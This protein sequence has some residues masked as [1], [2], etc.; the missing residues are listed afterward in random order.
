MW[1]YEKRLQFPVRIKNPDARA[2]KIIISQFGGPDGELAA[3]MRYLSQRYATPYRNVAGILTDIGTE[4][5]AHMEMVCAIVHQLTRD[6]TIEQI[7]A[8]G[9]ADYFVDHTL[10][11]YPVA[12]SGAPFTATYFQSKGDIIT[13]L[14]EDMAA[15]QKARTTY[16]NILRLVDDPDILEP[17]RF[18]RERE[19]VHYQRFGEALRYVQDQLQSP[20]FYACNPGFDK[21]CPEPRC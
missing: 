16:D 12:A 13:D 5:L 9:F 1:S 21:C 20:N 3:S 17:I 2:A 18:L 10:G 6:L 11:V 15:E 19:I 14:H 8:Q 7:K 4:E